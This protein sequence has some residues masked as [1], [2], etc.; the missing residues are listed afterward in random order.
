MLYTLEDLK[1][2]F[3]NAFLD[4]AQLELLLLVANGSD[5][6][7]IKKK[8]SISTNAVLKRMGNIYPKLGIEGRRGNMNRIKKLM[9]ERLAFKHEKGKTLITYYSDAEKDLAIG[10][11]QIL[12]ANPDSDF[13][14]TENPISSGKKW[15]N[16]LEA[17]LVKVDSSIACF[18]HQNLTKPMANSALGFLSAHF[19]S[20]YFTYFGGVRPPAF[21][22]WL[23]GINGIDIADLIHLRDSLI[24]DSLIK[25]SSNNSKKWIKFQFDDMNWQDKIRKCLV[26][27]NNTKENEL[28]NIKSDDTAGNELERNELV[29]ESMLQL[30]EESTL[31]YEQEVIRGIVE[32]CLPQDFSWLATISDQ[33]MLD[34]MRVKEEVEREL[35]QQAF[36]RSN[37]R[38]GGIQRSEL[39]QTVQK[40]TDIV[41]RI[42][43]FPI[44]ACVLRVMQEGKSLKQRGLCYEPGI[45]AITRD[46]ADREAGKG[47]VHSVIPS[48]RP[49]IVQDIDDQLIHSFLNKKWIDENNLGSFITFPV[50]NSSKMTG[51]N[52]VEGTFSLYGDRYY[53]IFNHPKHFYFVECLVTLL[54][55]LISK[56]DKIK[57]MR[58]LLALNRERP[59]FYISSNNF[60][61]ELQEVEVIKK[62]FFVYG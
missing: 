57:A 30:L 28:K 23:T 26:E 1:T 18:L 15:K 60:P 41:G 61:D 11:S 13:I 43:D 27:N 5:T 36:Y 55:Q 45:T 39:E 38:A 31:R 32:K 10:L 51:E 37:I 24:K 7:D 53:A 40:I 54:A 22:D 42:K 3:S 59:Q 14:F 49:L 52:K 44:K 34:V 48:Q 19:G 29:L 21:L 9:S 20:C 50:M 47:L 62:R 4:D 8:L 35:I 12:S 17:N 46:T 16:E 33:L 2:A 56:I 58:T 6:E 25:D